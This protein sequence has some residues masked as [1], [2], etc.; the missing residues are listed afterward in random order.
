M[1]A[2]AEHPGKAR[3]VNRIRDNVAKWAGL[4]ALFIS[5]GNSAFN[6][7]DQRV[8]QP[9]RDEIIR[10]DR[11]VSRFEDLISQINAINADTQQRMAAAPDDSTRLQ[12]LAAGSYRVGPL[13]ERA[14]DLFPRVSGQVT[15]LEL[16]SLAA[17][18][19]GTLG[20]DRALSFMQQATDAALRERNLAVASN[21]MATRARLI[22]EKGA[23]TGDPAA[24]SEAHALIARSVAILSHDKSQP[25]VWWHAQAMGTAATFEALFGDCAQ[26]RA[27]LEQYRAAAASLGINAEMRKMYEDSVVQALGA[28]DRCGLKP[29][30]AGNA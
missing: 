17:S 4:A 19:Y 28:A 9:R 24:L 15:S 11:D 12:M 29:L 25:V 30:I 21:L 1:K 13:V 22:A 16:N 6:V 26:A 2:P 23:A 5:L 18:I 8:L 27:N 20:R 7:Y 10:R 3:N 14:A